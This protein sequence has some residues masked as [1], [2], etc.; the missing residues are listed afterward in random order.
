MGSPHCSSCC[1]ASVYSFLLRGLSLCALVRFFSAS[2]SPLRCSFFSSPSS[3]PL[4][5]TFPIAIGGF[6]AAFPLFCV[7]AS[8]FSLFLFRFLLALSSFV[9][10]PSPLSLSSLSSFAFFSPLDCVA[11][12]SC[13]P[14][15]FSSV[16]FHSFLLLS[17][18]W[19]AVTCPF[20]LLI[21]FG[22]SRRRWF[23]IL[24]SALVVSCFCSSPSDCCFIF[25][26]SR[27]LHPFL[28]RDDSSS[29]VALPP[30]VLL[31]SSSLFL[32]LYGISGASLR[33][34]FLNRLLLL[35]VFFPLLRVLC[36]LG[37]TAGFS[38]PLL[39]GVF[40][41]ASASFVTFL[42]VLALASSLSSVLFDR[43]PLRDY[44]SSAPSSLS[45]FVLFAFTC[46]CSLLFAFRFIPQV[47]LP[48]VFSWRVYLW[49]SLR[50]FVSC[51]FRRCLFALC[52]H[53]FLP[54][55]LVLSLSESCFVA[56]LF[57]FGAPSLPSVLRPAVARCVFSCACFVASAYFRACLLRDSLLPIL[58]CVLLGMPLRFNSVSSSCLSPLL[59]FAHLAL[60]LGLFL[61]FLLVFSFLLSAPSLA[62]LS[63]AVGIFLSVRPLCFLASSAQSQFL[64]WALDVF[65][66][67]VS[68]L[69]LMSVQSGAWCL[70]VLSFSSCLLSV[71]L[72]AVSS[73][74]YDSIL[75]FFRPSFL[76]FLFLVFSLLLS[77]I[78]ALSLAA[79]F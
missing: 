60:F 19:F 9:R 20:F 14:P 24:C 28:S 66:L 55:W 4:V 43:F 31:S 15:S 62:S 48:F 37:S 26:S 7:C 22:R 10:H 45:F 23:F 29:S 76:F 12:L 64:V 53:Y 65:C 59:C 79:G 16:R 1:L 18:P 41:V 40:R 71:P 68:S 38:S 52:F 11:S 8:S 5:L 39:P 57:I 13:F 44:A 75:L 46:F 54:L 49:L 67:F 36:S 58:E 6:H 42:V 34:F 78:S 73:A 74:S 50:F 2:F 77:L 70:H 61:L 32:L 33:C 69:L 63:C 25:A 56:C 27:L 47:S 17:F 35:L 21:P 30:R 72:L 51:L 3:L